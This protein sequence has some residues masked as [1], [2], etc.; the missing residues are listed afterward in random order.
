MTTPKTN[1]IAPSGKDLGE[2]F[3]VR[4]VTDPS[5]AITGCEYFDTSTSTYKDLSGLFLPY[6][7]ATSF[8]TQ[9][10]T[11]IFSQT[12][13]DLNVVFQYNPNSPYDVISTSGTFTQVSGSPNYVLEFKTTSLTDGSF[14]INFFA[15]LSI[16][17]LVVGGGGGGGGGVNKTSASGGGGGS[18]GIGTL[19]AFSSVVSSYDI[20]VGAGGGAGGGNISGSNG[21]N[22]SFGTLITSTGGSGGA[23]YFAGSGGGQ[24]GSSS[25]TGIT[26]YHG[27]KGGKGFLNWI[28]GEN[29]TSAE[30]IPLPGPFGSYSVGGGGGGGGDGSGSGGTAA[31]NGTLGLHSANM[32]PDGQ[33][34][35]ITS[36]G[37]GAGGGK[38]ISSTSNGGI[39]AP[40]VVVIQ[41]TYP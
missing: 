18:G 28:S 25:G 26:N 1:Y 23:G 16:N 20:T 41:F 13:Q 39:G 9:S 38:Y 29:G 31:L 2:I 30:S 10:S 4:Q 35:S 15:N 21:H 11:Q 33:N 37:S 14:K 7:S 17:V 32:V 6:V 34:A 36:Y 12:G 5:S 3:K 27:G 8:S 40:G 24:E 19:I 22:S